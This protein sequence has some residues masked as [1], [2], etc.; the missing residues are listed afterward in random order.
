MRSLA[1]FGN[2]PYETLLISG[3]VRWTDGRMMHKSYGNFVE[4]DEAMNR[5]GADPL[6]QWAA[7]GGSTGSDIPFRWTELDHG[8][9]FLTKLWNIARFVL[10]SIPAIPESREMDELL[11]LDKWLL[12]AVQDLGKPASEPCENFDV[13]LAR[14]DARD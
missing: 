2:P 5:Y 12:G 7:S 9:K 13:A 11:L 10:T 3:M 8:K 4:A 1:K 6:R 14:A